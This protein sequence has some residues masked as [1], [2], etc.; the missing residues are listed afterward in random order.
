MPVSSIVTGGGRRHT[1]NALAIVGNR[2]GAAGFAVGKATDLGDAVEKAVMRASRHLV[3]IDRK[4]GYTIHHDLSAKCISTTV[5]MMP[6]P[7]AHGLV[8]HRAILEISQLAGIESLI[9]NVCPLLFVT[10]VFMK[11]R[12]LIR[13]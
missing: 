12:Q 10:H 1:M 3:P 13:P 5:H 4:D 2:N 7:K 9:A 8:A 6:A 11:L